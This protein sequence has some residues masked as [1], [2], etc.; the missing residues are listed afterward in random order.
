MIRHKNKNLLILT[1]F[2]LFPTAHFIFQP[3]YS[4]TSW[5]TWIALF[6]TMFLCIK[7]R[8]FVAY[9]IPFIALLS[10][11]AT[12]GRFMTMLPSEL[13]IILITFYALLYFIIQRKHTINIK[14][15]DSY[16][17]F[18]VP[19]IF[20]SYLLSFEIY[21]LLKSIISWI[22][23]FSVFILTKIVLKS[24]KDVNNFLS[25]VACAAFY[26]SLIIIA[27]YLNGVILSSFMISESPEIFDLESYS[28]FVRASNFYQN[29]MFVFGPATLIFISKAFES[30]NLISSIIFLMTAGIILSTLLLLQEKTG[31][32]ALAGSILVILFLKLFFFKL[33]R[34]PKIH[35]HKKMI[36]YSMI[37]LIA[38][39]LFDFFSEI[40]TYVLDLSSFT[41]RL[42]VYESTISV[43]M[44]NP[45][46]LL[47]G[48]GPD[49]SNLLSSSQILKAQQCLSS[50]QG[51]IDSGWMTF[52]FEYGLIFISLLL[53]FNLYVLIQL[54]Y[55]I[56]SR[57]HLQNFYLILFSIFIFINLAALTDVVG[58][59]KVAWVYT[60]FFAI[61]LISFSKRWAIPDKK[62]N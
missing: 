43:L 51:A 17:L 6:L 16:L 44:D 5:P 8:R 34:S 50:Q 45:A 36:A 18:L 58:T 20:I 62:Y 23:I 24:D 42:C 49:S 12:N 54:I 26:N 47:F 22:I 61:V 55:F 21:L 52:L 3:S 28:Y 7:D 46:R 27:A 14:T 11:L 10:P 37:P 60:Q 59:A 31:L 38:Y 53:I 30:K 2:W 29:I 57:H 25:M 33:P 1:I 41:V 15:G 48:F 40:N 19:I 39:F 4:I 13:F 56:K 35:M 32:V 9:S